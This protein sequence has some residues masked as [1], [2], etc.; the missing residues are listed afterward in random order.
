MKKIFIVL[1]FDL[2][3]RLKSKKS[4]IRKS[5]LFW[6]ILKCSDHN[7]KKNMLSLS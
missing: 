7:N 2:V 5:F 4:E 6:I 1:F 3:K